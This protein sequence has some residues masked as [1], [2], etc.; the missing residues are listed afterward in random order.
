MRLHARRT[1]AMTFGSLLLLPMYT[2]VSKATSLLRTL[3]SMHSTTVTD[4]P[5]Q[6]RAEVASAY[7]CGRKTQTPC[8]PR[9]PRNICGLR[10]GWL[11]GNAL[12]WGGDTHLPFWSRFL[13]IPAVCPKGVICTA[14]C[15]TIPLVK[16]ASSSAASSCRPAREALTEAAPLPLPAAARC[17]PPPAFCTCA[18]P[19]LQQ[20]QYSHPRRTLVGQADHKGAALWE[21]CLGH[22]ATR[23]AAG[24][25]CP[26][27]SGSPSCWVNCASSFRF[28][29][30]VLRF[31]VPCMVVLSC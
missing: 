22:A 19:A 2:L 13:F 17:A 23:T 28:A 9:D 20:Q 31:P 27:V 30:S 7:S 11:Q 1:C 3:Q 6:L 25:T 21:K 4:K 14:A 5:A 26:S 29:F 15:S 18:R 12:D 8:A 10:A 16:A 24:R